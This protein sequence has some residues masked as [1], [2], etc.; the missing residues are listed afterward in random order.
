MEAVKAVFIKEI[1]HYF[2]SITGYVFGGLLLMFVGIYTVMINLD[3]GSPNFEYVLA[4][5]PLIFII[6]VPILTMR[7]IAE[8]RRRR[9][10]QLLYSL[11][12]GT[13][14]VVLG[15]YFAM[16][17]VVLIPMFLI[18]FI[19]IILSSLGT[20]NFFA[21]YSSVTGFTMLAAALVSIGMFLS[22]LT[23]NTA[24]AA[25]LCFLA[26]LFN[27]FLSSLAAYIPTDSRSSLIALSTIL[28][29]T[30][31]VMWLLTKNLFFSFIFFT[32]TEIAL[33]VI[34]I[35]F[36]SYFAGLFA[37]IMNQ[38]SLFE[39]FSL[40]QH[41]IFDLNA[42]FYYTSVCVLFLFMTVQSLEKRRWS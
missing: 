4:G 11:P 41:A 16:I 26:M 21:A 13:T 9:T 28:L 40:F 18:C 37:S 29:L 5:M 25:G 19:P 35:L 1:N 22:S 6:L 17:A 15:K 31:L 10:D 3:G 36:S 23:D 34:Y 30:G 32:V 8:E 39:R 38:I 24:V 33:C 7:S 20:I 14:R 42:V 27:Y 12:L 2:K